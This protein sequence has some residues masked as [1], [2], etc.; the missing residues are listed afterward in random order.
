MKSIGEES[1]FAAALEEAFGASD[2]QQ[3]VLID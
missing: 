1:E 3:A 2:E